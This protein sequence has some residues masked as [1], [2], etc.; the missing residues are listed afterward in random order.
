MP[1]IS[2][3]LELNL[4][5]YAINEQG[6]PG[7]WFLSLDANTRL[8]VWWAK[9]FFRL[10]YVYAKMDYTHDPKSGRIDYKA[11]RPGTEKRLA[12]HFSYQPLGGTR[13][14]EPGSLDFFLVERYILFSQQKDGTIQTGQVH[15]PPYEY[16]DAESSGSDILFELNGLPRPERPADHVAMCKS[17]DVDIFALKSS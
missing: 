3:F 12:S 6:V 8:G 1:G 10:P 15:H 13:T 7:V 14:A 9:T 16:S 5:T 17:V 4:R 2:N 11:H